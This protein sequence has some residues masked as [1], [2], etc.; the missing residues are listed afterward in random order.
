MYYILTVLLCLSRIYEMDS[1][2]FFHARRFTFLL[3][4][5]LRTPM[6]FFALRSWAQKCQKKRRHPP[7]SGCSCT[8]QDSG[9]IP[10]GPLLKEMQSLGP[11]SSW[12]SLLR[13]LSTLAVRSECLCCCLI[14]RSRPWAV[15][16]WPCRPAPAA[17]WFGPGFLSS[18][19]VGHLSRSLLWLCSCSSPLRWHPGQGWLGTPLRTSLHLPRGGLL[20]CYILSDFL[21]SLSFWTSCLWR[22]PS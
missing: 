5:S 14:A 20:F 6:S 22:G 4:F 7:L 10:S 2:F 3:L 19:V 18:H 1:C 13:P 12:G 11:W 8:G 16:P 15:L 9:T 17:G 21:D